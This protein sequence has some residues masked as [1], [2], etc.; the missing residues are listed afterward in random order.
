MLSA[1]TCM[2]ARVVAA[3]KAVLSQRSA[4]DDTDETAEEDM[5]PAEELELDLTGVLDEEQ[6]TPGLTLHRESTATAFLP[7]QDVTA[8]MGLSDEVDADENED[9][10]A[11]IHSQH[12]APIPVHH[13]GATTDEGNEHPAGGCTSD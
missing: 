6:D 1:C 5:T 7:S 3:E 4:S 10:H 8:K 12:R 11:E 2:Q 13:K 9:M